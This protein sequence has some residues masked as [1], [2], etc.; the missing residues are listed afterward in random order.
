VP[1]TVV[2]TFTHFKLEVMVYRAIV[3]TESAL[4]FWADPNRCTWV[5][6]RDLQAQAL[7]T[8]MRKIIAHGLAES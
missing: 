6:R 4:T 1:G 2:H 3:A 7:P 8:V 5:A